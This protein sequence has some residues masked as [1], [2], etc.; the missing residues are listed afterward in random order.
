[1][2]VEQEYQKV[3][4][5]ARE[6]VAKRV[7]LMQAIGVAL[8][9]LVLAHV[10]D[11]HQSETVTNGVVG[12]IN[13]LASL[14]GVLW[15]RDATTPADPALQPKSTTGEPLVPVTTAPAAT[16]GPSVAA[17]SGAEFGEP[18]YATGSLLESEAAP[19]A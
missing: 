9:V 15:S 17:D 7:L 12:A 16:V 3:G 1:M 14:V 5:W 10:L 6:I 8:S 13:G 11:V 4:A 19:T 18:V 2:S